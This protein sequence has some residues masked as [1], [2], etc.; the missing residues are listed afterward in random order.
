MANV[1]C[2]TKRYAKFKDNERV[3]ASTS[4][5]QAWPERPPVRNRI[6]SSRKKTKTKVM[7]AGKRNSRPSIV[8]M[9]MLQLRYRLLYSIECLEK[10]PKYLNTPVKKLIGRIHSMLNLKKK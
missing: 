4:S 9:I 8:K 5:G 1:S 3:M 6:G 10:E 7:E 2:K